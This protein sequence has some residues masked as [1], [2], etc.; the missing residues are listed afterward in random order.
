MALSRTGVSESG[1]GPEHVRFQEA[2]PELRERAVRMVVEVR[3][4]D[5]SHG[6]IARI[7]DQLG[8]HRLQLQSSRAQWLSGPPQSSPSRNEATSR[9]GAWRGASEVA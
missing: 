8:I 9:V 3:A 6:S 5:E 7:A 2:S 1:K 4:T